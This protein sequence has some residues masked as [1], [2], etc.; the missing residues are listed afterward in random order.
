ME[1]QF[2]ELCR[3]GN[4]DDIKKL[5]E[6]QY[7]NIHMS[8]EYGFRQACYYGQVNIKMLSIFNRYSIYGCRN[9][10]PCL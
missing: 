6:T 5:I 9:Y 1:E 4:L 2:I 3:I 8:D 10:K 7:V